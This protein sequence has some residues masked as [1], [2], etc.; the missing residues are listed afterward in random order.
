L[1]S[2][3]LTLASDKVRESA[4]DS[5]PDVDLSEADAKAGMKI[6]MK[7]CVACHKANGTGGQKTTA[8]G[9]PS[10]NFRDPKYW[11]GKTNGILVRATE[12][13]I[14]RSGMVAFTGVLKREEIL[15]VTAYIVERYQPKK[16]REK[17]AEASAAPEDSTT[18]T[19]TDSES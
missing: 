18:S 19:K 5:L 9:S 4:A 10:P 12:D 3:N 7:N 14:P 16:S 11:Q 1:A 15:D 2:T 8:S 17:E 13:G 6:Y